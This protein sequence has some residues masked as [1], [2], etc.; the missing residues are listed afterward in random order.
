MYRFFNTI[1]LFFVVLCSGSCGRPD[2][3]P[4]WTFFSKLAKKIASENGQELI[5]SD[6][7]LEVALEGKDLLWAFVVVDSRNMTLEEAKQLAAHM[8]KTILEAVRAELPLF[9][10]YFIRLNRE[11]PE[12]DPSH[13]SPRNFGFRVAFWDK[14]MDRPFPPYIAQIQAVDG[15]V[16]FYYADPKTQ[17]LEQPP[18][19]K[20]SYEEL[21]NLK[22]LKVF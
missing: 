5:F 12:R 6:K 16:S 20:I 11:Y 17:A 2:T 3:I 14:N 15:W 1:L 13:L 22:E 19:A 18:A 9:E 4:T 10:D 21:L 8:L 7:G